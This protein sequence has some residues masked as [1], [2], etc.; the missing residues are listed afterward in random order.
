MFPKRNIADPRGEVR[1]A[2]GHIEELTMPTLVQ[3]LDTP[4]V[5]IDLDIVAGNIARAQE[6]VA[7]QGLENRPDIQTHKIRGWR[8]WRWT[9]APS[10]LPGR[11]WARSSDCD[12]GVAEKSGQLQG[13]GNP[14]TKGCRLIRV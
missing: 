6:T 5:V 13:V 10:A 7:R 9:P 8:N 3:D 12:S 2:P 14:K 11:S 4:G 1:F